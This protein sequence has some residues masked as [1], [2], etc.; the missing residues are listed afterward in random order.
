MET[1]FA[2]SLPVLAT[3]MAAAPRTLARPRLCADGTVEHL[4]Y[5][6]MCESMCDRCFSMTGATTFSGVGQPACACVCLRVPACVPACHSRYCKKGGCWPGC[7]LRKLASKAQIWPLPQ[8]CVHGRLHATAWHAGWRHTGPEAGSTKPE[9]APRCAVYQEEDGQR[10]RNQLGTQPNGLAW[11][12]PGSESCLAR[13]FI[14][15]LTP[16]G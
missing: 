7:A 11:R 14:P 8:A 10:T 5:A 3:L 15:R 13:C 16:P 4:F 12:N 2:T 6:P 1:R 9:T